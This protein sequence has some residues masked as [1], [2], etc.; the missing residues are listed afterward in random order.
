[1]NSF[2]HV[3]HR[4]GVALVDFAQQFCEL[5]FVHWG[6]RGWCSVQF[7]ERLNIPRSH[8]IYGGHQA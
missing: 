1:M 3:N 7:F 5:F 2:C 6:F 4:W 8:D